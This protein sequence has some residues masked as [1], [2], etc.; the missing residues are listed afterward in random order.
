MQIRAIRY[1]GLAIIIYIGI[2]LF[3]HLNRPNYGRC[4][5]YTKELNGGSKEFHGT[6]Y[7]A[8]LCGADIKNGTEVKF[9]FFDASGKLL[10]QRYFSYYT[11]SAS[12]RDLID[13]MDSIIYYDNSKSDVMRS[14]SIPP[15][16]WDWL[17]AR[18]PL[19]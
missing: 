6:T 12:E 3:F 17:R 13:A 2:G 14:L 18:L 4:D 5:F 16:K 10:A 19:F 9:Q 11:N 15:T 7:F 8:K 1:I